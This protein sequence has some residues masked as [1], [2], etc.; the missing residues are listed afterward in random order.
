MLEYDACLIAT[1]SLPILPELKNIDEMKNISMMRNVEDHKH[2]RSYLESGS[3]KST[4]PSSVIF[5][6]MDLYQLE[7]KIFPKEYKK[8]VPLCIKNS[9]MY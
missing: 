7:P 5:F 4:L 8:D 9:V 6:D 3:V 1:E 2:L